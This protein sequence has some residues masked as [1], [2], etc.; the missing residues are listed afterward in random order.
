MIQ[1]VWYEELK[2]KQN[3]FSIKPQNSATIVGRNTV[4]EQVLS[5][6]SQN[7]FIVVEGDYGVG[8]TTMLKR[9][10][11]KFGGVRKV[12]YF[13][14]NRLTDSL[15]IDRLLLNRF[16]AVTRVLRIKSKQMI[17]LLDEAQSLSEQDIKDLRQYHLEGY[18]R[19]VV[20]VTHDKRELK[21]PNSVAMVLRNTTFKLTELSV[22]DAISLVRERIGDHPLLSDEVIST[23]YARDNRVRAFL[24]NCDLFMR[25]MV[26]QKRKVAKASDVDKI[27]DEFKF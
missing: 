23:I 24:K 21:L 14:C 12:I 15:D 22:E 1:K 13:S 6:I 26:T 5:A 20:L 16:G 7:Q 19:A 2:Y 4:V 27:L 17:L 8:K 3:P 10:I 11:S 9:I 18:L 25:Y